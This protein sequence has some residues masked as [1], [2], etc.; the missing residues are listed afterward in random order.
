MTRHLSG[1]VLVALGLV[2]GAFTFGCG[3]KSPTGPTC[4]L[5]FAPTGVTLESDGGSGSISVTAPQGCAWTA[6]TTDSWITI[7]SGSGSG[8]GTIAYTVTANPSSDART[9]AIS[10]GAERIQVTQHGRS[11]QAC[12]Y[13]VA[14]STA[15]F[16]KDGGDGTFTV[17]APEGCAWTARSNASWLTVATPTGSGTAAVSYSVARHTEVDGRSGTITVADRTLTVRQSGDIGICT[18]AVAPV[19]FTPC[20]PGTTVKTTISTPASCPW[21]ASVNV[22]WLRLSATAGAGSTGLS[23]TFSDNYDAPRQGTVMI[24][25]P[26]PTAGQ[27]VRVSQAGCRY[28]VSRS[29]F[30]FVAAGGSGTFDVLQQS[31][32]TECGGA[33]QD[34]CVWTALSNASWIVVTTPMPRSGDN[35]VAFTVAPNTGASPRTGTITVRDRVVT[36]TQNGQ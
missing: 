10:V 17:S 4:T 31:D 19:D 20:M 9:G 33:L 24:R 8:P 34:R 36:I 27:N 3:T 21:T 22:P 25:W 30:A 14:P 29:S 2:I 12:T 28:G 13:D 26:T 35:P 11:A 15:D 6:T 32:P 5:T 18:Y 16:S 1:G 23:I 7:G